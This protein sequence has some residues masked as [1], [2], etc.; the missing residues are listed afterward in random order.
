M[1]YI[2]YFSECVR[3]LTYLCGNRS[4][5][6]YVGSV[7]RQQHHHKAKGA[8]QQGVDRGRAT[9]THT[10]AHKTPRSIVKQFFF[11][12][13]FCCCHRLFPKYLPPLFK[14]PLLLPPS[15][16]LI[17]GWRCLRYAVCVNPYAR[18]LPS[19]RKGCRSARATPEGEH[20][21]CSSANWIPNSV[22]PPPLP[23]SGSWLS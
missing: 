22:S 12:F 15:L 9:H 7:T 11:C 13:C 6:S 16:I 17:P 10:H 5:R 19:I 21:L 1:V 8:W 20:I 4:L 23:P 14:P 2:G 18:R 3:C